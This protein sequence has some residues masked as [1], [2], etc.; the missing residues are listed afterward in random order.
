MK[1]NRLLADRVELPLRET[2][3]K[4]SGGKSVTVSTAD[5]AP[6]RVNGT[7]G[8]VGHGAT[9]SETYRQLRELAHHEVADLARTGEPLPE[10]A[11]RPMREAGLA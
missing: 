11:T 6:P 5:A 4:W 10:P 1:I 7:H 8:G 9:D 3:Y 2:S